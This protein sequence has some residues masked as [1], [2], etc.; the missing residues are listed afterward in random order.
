MSGSALQERKCLQFGLVA[1]GLPLT[2]AEVRM[3]VDLMGFGCICPRLQAVHRSQ[4]SH[5]GSMNKDS[6][7][8]NPSSAVHYGDRGGAGYIGNSSPTAGFAGP[9]S[10][11]RRQKDLDATVPTEV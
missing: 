11:S 2:K 3:F 9:C 7:A 4:P 6:S 5:E 10:A 8:V 1:N